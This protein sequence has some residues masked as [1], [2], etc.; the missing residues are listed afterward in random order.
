M[1]KTGSY[2][3][4]R[5]IRGAVK[6]FYPKFNIEGRE[7]LPDEPCL[8]VGNH[9]QMNGPIVCELYPPC[10]CC[11]WC[12]GEMMELKEVPAYAYKDFWSEKPRAVRCFYKLL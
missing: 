1:K 7:N 11:T 6:L 4:F 5:I 2:P 8:I 12:A 3:I 9:S 10:P